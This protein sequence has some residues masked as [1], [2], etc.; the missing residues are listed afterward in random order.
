MYVL[1]YVSICIIFFNYGIYDD[2]VII[3]VVRGNI[4]VLVYCIII[5]KIYNSILMNW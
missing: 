1:F 3:I 5:M 2:F 4:Y